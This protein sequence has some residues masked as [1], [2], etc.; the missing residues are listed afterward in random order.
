LDFSTGG[1]ENEARCDQKQAVFRI[2]GVK[3][4]VKN[5]N[6]M[7]L[8][9]GSIRRWLE[10]MMSDVYFSCRVCLKLLMGKANHKKYK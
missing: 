9:L 10:E 4:R 2:M 8:D 6:N 7:A 5:T 3:A 1:S